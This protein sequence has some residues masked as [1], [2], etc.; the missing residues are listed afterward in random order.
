M[1]SGRGSTSVRDLVSSDRKG[2]P[3]RHVVVLET[4][5]PPDGTTRYIDQVVTFAGPRF[6]FEYLRPRT[7]ARMRFDVMHV[8]WPEVLVRGRSRFAVALR[9]FGLVLVTWILRLRRVP[10]VRTVH[11]VTPHEAGSRLEA[12]AL[13]VLDRAT[14]LFVTINPTTV[15]PLER[16][17][18]IPHG[19]YR[20]RFASFDHEDAVS[21][22]FVYAGLIR[23]YKGVEALMRAFVELDDA[24]ATLRIVGK[25]TPELRGEVERAAAAC[26]SI[27]A[28]LE[29]VPDADLVAEITAG[30]LVCLPYHELHNSGIM[31]V[32]LSLGRPVLVPDTEST[33]AL[34]AEVGDEWVIRY[35]G[36][37]TPTV[38]GDALRIASATRGSEPMLDGRDWH[39]VADSY[40][41]AFLE[42]LA[43]VGRAGEFED[44]TVPA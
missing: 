41:A 13:R 31:L 23:P 38:L 21:G 9:C 1:E 30:S 8:H 17:V 4:T 10:I 36:A 7:L 43:R 14:T 18:Y 29:F 3:M 24:D 6:R 20:D 42:A 39:R 33:R 5:G 12:W 34:G 37:L 28:R 11:N 22:R 16:S 35:E 27:S 40:G 25:P 19:H 2:E 15:A 44:G 26:A 32:A